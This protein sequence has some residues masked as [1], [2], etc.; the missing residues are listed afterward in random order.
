MRHRLL[1]VPA[2]LSLTTCAPGLAQPDV[3][4]LIDRPTA[5]SRAELTRA[6]SRAL[7]G[8]PVT[9]ADDALTRESSLIIEK[10]HRLGRDFDKPER[11][12]LVKAGKQCVLVHERT[13][14]RT[15]LASASCQPLVP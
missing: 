5:D 7:N 9:L 11:F 10:A 13:G 12:R 2:V 15:L 1:A 3:A 8:A 6:V 14:M 4:A